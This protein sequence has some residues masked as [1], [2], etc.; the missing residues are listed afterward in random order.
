MKIILNIIFFICIILSCQKL[1]PITIDSQ[2][3]NEVLPDE[4]LTID[5]E[6]RDFR[7]YIP[8]NMPEK[9]TVIIAF[10]GNGGNKISM[11]S[12]TKFDEVADKQG[13]LVVYPNAIDKQ[14]SNNNKAKDLKFV[15]QLVAHI[16][17]KYKANNNK[18]FVMGMSNG[19]YF[20]HQI[21]QSQ[22]QQIAGVIAHSAS[23]GADVI[24]GINATKK[25][26]V[27]IIHGDRDNIVN[28]SLAKSSRD[29][30]VK[31]KHKVVYRE[32]VGLGHEWANQAEINTEI[33]A[34][35]NSTT[36]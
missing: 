5:G 8:K 11:A 20:T 18:F 9:P 16:K 1:K 22:S 29:L 25:F 27:M 33:T 24:T 35:I 23:L 36:L 15:E 17:T 3:T 34:F 12:S 6:K 7:V 19:G 28:I 32:V 21:G 31:E 10:H 30:Y 14:W 2:T 4:F 26:P 13:Y